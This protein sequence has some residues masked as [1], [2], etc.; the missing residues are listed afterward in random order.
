MTK[1]LLQ[2]FAGSSVWWAILIRK[3]SSVEC[4]KLWNVELALRH[5]RVKIFFY[6]EGKGNFQNSKKWQSKIGNH[7]ESI[8]EQNAF[9]GR[10][11][12]LLAHHLLKITSNFRSS[13][14][15]NRN[16]WKSSE[17]LLRSFWFTTGAQIKRVLCRLIIK[18]RLTRT[19]ERSRLGKNSFF[20]S[21]S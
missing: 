5:I 9:R 7:P 13:R 21:K 4:R 12:R 14:L 17:V 8:S 15:V 10:S 20:A 3:F 16:C 11:G 18:R 6:W 1:C 2:A 19:S